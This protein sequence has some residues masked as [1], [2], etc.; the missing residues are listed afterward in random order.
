MI[1]LSIGKL[2]LLALI[3]LIVLGPEKLPGVA[4]TAGAVLRRMRGSWNSVRA[5]VER[6]LQVEELKRASREV[7]EH[8]RAAEAGLRTVVSTVQQPLQQAAMLLS[9]PVAVVGNTTAY[10]NATAL[11]AATQSSNVDSSHSAKLA[12]EGLL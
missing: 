9:T 12:G 11:S 4:R 5:E 7:A 1:D 10:G 6:E 2:F 3:A 8:S